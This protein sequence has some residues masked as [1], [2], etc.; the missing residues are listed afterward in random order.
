M[1]YVHHQMKKVLFLIILTILM[2]YSPPVISQDLQFYRED[3][4]FQ[5]QE[6]KVITDAEYYFCNVGDKDIRTILF[7]PF[8]AQTMDLID[9]LMVLDMGSKD[10]IPYREGRSG[11]FFE[12]FVK[13][14]EQTAYRVFFR[15]KENQGHFKYIL[16][17]TASW[18]RP[19]E[20]A[21]YELQMPSS[22]I[23]DSLSYSPDTSFI[24]N[25]IKHFIWKKA[26]FMP[27]KDFEVF[28]FDSSG[29]WR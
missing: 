28:Y 26:D 25:D 24:Q 7:Y 3:I 20:F 23:L 12:I 22:F 8:P 21:G 13:A 1:Q 29:T 2:S 17:S 11:I 16:N 15:Q 10:T 18:N 9:S 14:Y 4:V 5:I 6:D 27:D 19:L